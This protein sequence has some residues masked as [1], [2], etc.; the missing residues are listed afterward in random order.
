MRSR[1]FRA[2]GGSPYAATDPLRS[3][4]GFTLVELVIAIA[5][6]GITAATITF[7]YTGTVRGYIDTANRQDSVALARAA[8]DR[9]DRELREAMPMSVRISNN[10]LQFLPVAAS[11]VYVSV[12]ANS[13]TVSVMDFPVPAGSGYYAA[14]Y[15]IS[16]G[17]LYGLTA[18]Q[19]IGS[20]SAASGNLRTLILSSGFP[21]PR[22]SAGERL[23]IVGNPVSFCLEA[24]GQLNRYTSVVSATQALPGSGLVSPAMLADKLVAAQSSFRYQSGNWQNNALV[25]ITLTV[26]Q[27]NNGN[28]NEQLQ[29]DHEVWLRDVQ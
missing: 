27:A 26:Q 20:I 16:A 17:E 21:A 3:A 24:G 2:L 9:I 10:C 19:S 12:P 18:M 28:A 14:V 13:T 15:P 4:C 5:L 22:A 25:T 8:I 6:L 11:T 7:F 29:L 1:A 23:Y